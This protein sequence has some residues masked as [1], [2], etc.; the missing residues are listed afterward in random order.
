MIDSL[1]TYDAWQGYRKMTGSTKLTSRGF[2]WSYTTW[3]YKEK[4]DDDRIDFI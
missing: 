2:T 3:D 1:D 4:T